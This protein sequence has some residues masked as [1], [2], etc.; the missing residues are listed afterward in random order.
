LGL[1]PDMQFDTGTLLLEPGE[2]LV[3]FTDGIVE[4]R[5]GEGEAFGIDRLAAALTEPCV[6]ADDVR[7]RVLDALTGFAGG[8]EPADDVTLLVARKTGGSVGGETGG[9]MDG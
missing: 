7:D 8:A 5:N 9:R 1:L 6:S 4:G 2:S 3:V